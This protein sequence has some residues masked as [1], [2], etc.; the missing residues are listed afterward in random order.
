MSTRTPHYSPFGSCI[1]ELQYAYADEGDTSKYRFGFNGMERMYEI[2]LDGNA[3]SLGFR[4]YESRLGR[5]FKIDP[6]FYE[7]PWQSPYVY[8]L[9]NPVNQVDYLGGGDSTS[10]TD[11]A[12]TLLDKSN[13]EYKLGDDLYAQSEVKLKE[14]LN[15]LDKA[16][17]LLTDNCTDADISKSLDL[18]TLANK[19]FNEGAD[20]MKQASDH[21]LM[22]D[23]YYYQ[24]LALVP[25]MMEEYFLELDKLKE[26][27]DEAKINIV[28]N[29]IGEKLGFNGLLGTGVIEI[30]GPTQVKP[31]FMGS[32]PGTSR[33]SKYV[34]AKFPLNAGIQIPGVKG[35][36]IT[37]GIGRVAVPLML[38]WQTFETAESIHALYQAYV[39]GPTLEEIQFWLDD[40]EKWKK[41][42]PE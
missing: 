38:I 32:F 1:Q 6:R 7:Y 9:N 3:Y 39:N 17:A 11:K 37:R 35:A 14:G 8:H 16:E 12:S 26:W 33:W 36:S 21:V 29:I 42:N 40:F 15:L 24:A 18:M 27:R 5:M 20:L 10:A 2:Q 31:P 22:G 23:N 25:A 13:I 19:C 30:F 28:I 41:E 34:A 4:E